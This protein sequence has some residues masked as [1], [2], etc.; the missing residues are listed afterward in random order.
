MMNSKT[1]CHCHI[2][3]GLDDGARS[4]EESVALARRQ[5]SWGFGKV[6]CTSH[7]VGKYP[8]VPEVVTATCRM[9][10]E[11][12]R[13]REIPLELTPSME[14]RLIPETWPETLEK[15]WLLPWEGNHILIELPIHKASRI[16]NIVPEDEIKR[17]LDMG[18]QP[19]LAH[20]ERYLYLDGDRY[21]SLKDAGALFQRNV[22]SLEGLYGEAVSVRAEALLAERL[23]DL[24]GTDLHNEQYAD[25]FDGF[26][27]KA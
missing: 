1:D 11:E 19:V 9:L 16:G 7:R 3:P 21:H 12:L 23:F 17:L 14:Y 25:F 20:P 18:Y 4:L 5:V 8:N 27:F 15:G 13:K 22:G 26:G 10:Q 2:L 6:V 24:M